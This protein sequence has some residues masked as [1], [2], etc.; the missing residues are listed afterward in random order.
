[1]FIDL[2]IENDDNEK[3]EKELMIENQLKLKKDEFS[4]IN[5]SIENESMVSNVNQDGINDHHD[6]LMN[7]E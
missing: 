5:S 7:S 2:I 6:L 1:M 3:N 4:L